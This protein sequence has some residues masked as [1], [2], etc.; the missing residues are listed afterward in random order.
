MKKSLVEQVVGSPVTT[1]VLNSVPVAAVAM[2][3]D[4]SAILS[5]LLAPLANTIAAGR[6]E[7]RL[8]NELEQ[9]RKS[10][11]AIED[12]VQKFTDDQYKFVSE[13]VG[14][15]LTT[16]DEGKLKFLRDAVAT[17]SIDPAAVFKKA[18][19]LARLIRDLAPSEITFLTSNFQYRRIAVGSPEIRDDLL[20]IDENVDDAVS[21]M[22]LV[23]L[24]LLFASAPT[25]DLTI[26]AWSPLA[27]KII[28]LVRPHSGHAG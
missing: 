19:T 14:T 13:T 16:V 23:S 25:W 22:G 7:A 4:G 11:A 10:L 28:A 9:L 8:A 27:A 15:M 18:D 6:H 20:V 21:V 26:F 17:A 12:K 5:P 3:I 1:L 24:G 2:G